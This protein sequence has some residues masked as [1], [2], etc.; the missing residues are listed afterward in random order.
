MVQL[1]L[2]FALACALAA[3]IGLLCKHRGAVAAP[4]VTVRHP[5][6]SAAGL[7]RS[8]WW[9]IGFAI[10]FVA[11]GLH[12]AALAMAPLSLV[13]AVISGGLVLIALPAV[14]W[15]GHELG[16]R[17]WAGLGLSAAGLSLLALT[18]HSA[19]SHPHS[20][21]STSAMISFE[22]AA[23]GIG[24]LLVL[25]S[26]VERARERHG[27]LLG[28]AA[29]LLLGV[30]DVSVKALTGT[31]PG[32]P[33]TLIGP[34]TLVAVLCGVG[35]FYSFARG[36]QIGGA[37]QVITLSAVASNVAAVLGGVLVFD[38]PMGGDVL[39]V[40][41]RVAAFA[42]VI[43]AAALMPTPMRPVEARAPRAA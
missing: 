6:R 25:S 28:A 23:I 41:T 18:A 16:A 1:G 7:F 3:N 17:E 14:W 32:D 22:G 19:A 27:V 37:I 8:K 26:R 40:A 2:L 29:G 10:A 5:L 33:M 30:S 43:A 24:L 38:D 4:A 35:S 13:Q 31:V 15:F 34:W 12:V 20:D 21:Y 11:W 39:G 36:L 9:T 42:A